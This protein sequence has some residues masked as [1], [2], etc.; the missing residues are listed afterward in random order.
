MA[1]AVYDKNPININMCSLDKFKELVSDIISDKYDMDKW[2]GYF[3]SAFNGLVRTAEKNK[4][5]RR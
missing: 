2:R 5:N 3:F 4:A 1:D